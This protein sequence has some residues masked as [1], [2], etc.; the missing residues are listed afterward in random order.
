MVKIQVVGS[1]Y[2]HKYRPVIELLESGMK[3][4]QW[5]TL[6]TQDRMS[7]NENEYGVADDWTIRIDNYYMHIIGGYTNLAINLNREV[8]HTIECHGIKK[9]EYS[10]LEET[11]QEYIKRKELTY[12]E[13][14]LID[15]YTT[16]INGRLNNR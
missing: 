7:V 13:K 10:T 5:Y 9:P 14:L 15:D 11:K 8:P 2:G 1:K 3:G 16:F 4:A 6:R 12:S